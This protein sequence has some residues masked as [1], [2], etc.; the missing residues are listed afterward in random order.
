MLITPQSISLICPLRQY[1]HLAFLLVTSLSL[2]S[3]LPVSPLLPN[4]F[5]TGRPQVSVFG[6]IL[7]PI[8]PLDDHLMQFYAF[9]H[10]LMTWN[11]IPALFSE[12]C[13]HKFNCQF[14]I[15]HYMS[16][17]AFKPNIDTLKIQHIMPSQLKQYDLAN[18]P[19]LRKCQFHFSSCSGQNT[20]KI[21]LTSLWITSYN[22]TINNFYHFHLQNMFRIYITSMLTQRPWESIF[23]IATRAIL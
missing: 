12:F 10:I 9:K 14:H 21:S 2:Q 23:H 19:P 16:N 13:T 11:L 7:W 18:H 20:C 3:P 15:S 17:K 4:L 5:N 1:Y 6:T 22:Q 8:H